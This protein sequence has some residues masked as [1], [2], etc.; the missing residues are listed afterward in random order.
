MIYSIVLALAFSSFALVA[1][2]YGL[3]IVL[4]LRNRKIGEYRNA[5]SHATAESP[6]PETLPTVTIIM[7]AYNEETSI[8]AKFRNLVEARI[9]FLGTKNEDGPFEL[10]C[11]FPGSSALLVAW[12]SLCGEK[13]KCLEER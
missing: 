2:I 10:C 7:P 12:S 11:K 5:I 6:N 3:Y 8:P 4:I 13:E 1:I 9:L